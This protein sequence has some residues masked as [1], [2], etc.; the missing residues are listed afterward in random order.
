MGR[1]PTL[2]AVFRKYNR[3]YFDNKV[4]VSD[5]RF[6]RIRPKG[7]GE[8]SFF[9]DCPPIITVDRQLMSHGR[10]VRMVLLHEM[11]H[12]SAHHD[13]AHGPKFV[14]RIKR[15]VRQGAYDDLL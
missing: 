10:F 3:L 4:K 6:G 8:T 11:V 12:A 5:V 13:V 14:K 15:L 7:A 2:M 9:S 1:K